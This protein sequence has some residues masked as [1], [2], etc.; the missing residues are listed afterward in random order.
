M[1]EEKKK[2]SMKEKFMSMTPD[3][4]WELLI[5]WYFPSWENLAHNVKKLEKRIE[6][7]EKATY[8]IKL[9]KK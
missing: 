1:S 6:E 9:E 4:R 3:E 7:L 8:V 2:I 5:D